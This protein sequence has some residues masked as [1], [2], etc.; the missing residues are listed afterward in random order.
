[1]KKSFFL[2]AT[3]ALM[4]SCSSDEIVE[5][6]GKDGKQVPIL[7]NT[8]QQNITRAESLEKTE[9]YNFG[10]WARKVNTATNASDAQTVMDNYLVGW[11]NK[12]NKGYYVGDL[13][14]TYAETAGTV[15]DHTSPWFYEGLGTSEYT[16]SG[17]DGFYKK[18]Q[19][20]Y[21]SKNANQY[22]R[23]W[24]L[25]YSHTNFYCYAPYQSAGITPTL[26]A[27]GSAT[28]TFDG[29]NS[30]R[31]GYDAPI[32]SSY[33]SGD[34]FDRTLSEFMYAG[35]HAQ[36]SDLKDITVPFKHMGSQLFIRFYENVAGYKVE[37]LDLSGDN[38]TMSSAATDDQ[39]KGVQATP[40]V[41]GT[42]G[43]TLGEYYTTSGATIEFDKNAV[44]A[45]TP[46]FPTGDNGSLTT[47]ENLMFYAP[48]T[49]ADLYA[50]SNA[51]AAYRNGKGN[52]TEYAGL[53]S[54]KHYY[55]KEQGNTGTDQEY[56]WSP[57]IYY[58][59][60]QPQTGDD[61]CTNTGFT[62]HVTYRIIAEDNKE[63]ITVH[64]ATVFVP[65]EYTLWKAGTRYIYTFL[66]TRASTG[67]T[68]P[69]EEIDP[70][71]PTPDD[72]KALFPIVFDACT[73][74]D[75]DK[76]RSEWEISN[77]TSYNQ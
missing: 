51:S 65:K 55:I 22:L 64:N 70:T 48:S 58:P 25:A 3:V 54:T 1:M 42:S 37:I 23:Y 6:G 40:S 57:T 71:D 21:M 74:E 72:V 5:Q 10:V 50:K 68:N 8:N 69:T 62:F 41:K 56:S 46:T 66:I 60:A 11:S 59:V 52:L 73:I 28:L 67:T 36:N 45:F 15:T 7:L 20:A 19:S 18:T 2:L 12:S 27:D 38:G 14:T 47:S 26:N 49:N 35:V 30:V 13:T 63:V 76:N 34:A 31:D 32:N 53:G 77:G 61:K 33:T 39:K 24:D 9:H 43:Y 44:A 16:Y 75:Y 4:A 17:N 29:K